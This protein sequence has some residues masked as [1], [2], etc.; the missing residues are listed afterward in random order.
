VDMIGFVGKSKYFLEKED[1]QV[2]HKPQFLEPKTWTT[3][4]L[5]PLAS[6]NVVSAVAAAWQLQPS[7]GSSTKIA[8]HRESLNR[9]SAGD[10]KYI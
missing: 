3:S 4:L 5:S 1:F 7:E 6:M 9:V 2:F 10:M 8:K